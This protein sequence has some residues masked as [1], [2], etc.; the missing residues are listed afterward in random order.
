MELIYAGIDWADDHHDVHVT[1]DSAVVLDSFRIVHS[2][3]GIEK[4]KTRLGGL[5]SK[6]EDI[7]HRITCTST[8]S[9][10]LG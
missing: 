2:Y 7:F 8:Q 10:S 5:S 6:P 1:D 3:E 9:I 4:L